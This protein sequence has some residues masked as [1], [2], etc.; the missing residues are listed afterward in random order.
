MPNVAQVLKQEIS[1][2]ARKEAKSMALPLRRDVTAMRRAVAAL[3]R[4]AA[5]IDRAQRDLAKAL[6]RAMPAAA[7]PAEEAPARM[8]ITGPGVR[9]LRDRMRLTQGDFARLVGVSDQAVLLWEK[10]KG[11]LRLRGT[12]K[13]SLAAVRGLGAREARRRLTEMGVK[14]VS[15]PRR[16]RAEEAAAKKLAKKTARARRR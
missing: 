4:Q 8:R 7:A 3:K 11:T 5:S 15:R 10:N 14:K 2:L 1:R 16:R 6:A 9:S 12:T 13:A